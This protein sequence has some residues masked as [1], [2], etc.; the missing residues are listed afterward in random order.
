MSKKDILEFSTSESDTSRS[1]G[2]DISRRQMIR[3]TAALAAGGALISSTAQ[4]DKKKK[5]PKEEVKVPRKV[6]GKTKKSVPI[7]LFGAAV[8]LDPKFDPK[9]AQA[10]KYGVDY[11]DTAIVYGGGTSESAVGAFHTRAKLRDKLWITSK[12]PEH[13]PEA[14]ARKLDYSLKELR[15]DYTDLYFLHAVKDASVLNASIGKMGDKLKKQG[16]T[17]F[18]GFSCH[19]GNVAELM[20]KAAKQSWVDVIMFRYNFHQYGNKEL[21]AAIDACAKAN[22]GLIA[23][24]TQGSAASFKDAYWTPWASCER[25]LLPLW[26]RAT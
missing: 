24:K 16:K 22:I 9:L 14:F 23:M 20:M 15:T 2:G 1:L 13:E 26:T 21:N 3:D 5:K 19:H 7:L 10:Y 18:V 11:I 6:L 8:D 17:K 25:T 12:S 4:A